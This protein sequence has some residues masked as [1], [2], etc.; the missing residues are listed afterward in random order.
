MQDTDARVPHRRIMSAQKKGSL[1]QS[2][3]ETFLTLGQCAKRAYTSLLPKHTISFLT[4][5]IFVAGRVLVRRMAIRDQAF[6]PS[7]KSRR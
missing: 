7:S 2:V 4:Q 5:R 1:I 6:A 3:R